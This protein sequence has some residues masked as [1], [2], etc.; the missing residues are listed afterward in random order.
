M[1]HEQSEETRNKLKGLLLRLAARGTRRHFVLLFEKY[2]V[3]DIAEALSD[4]TLEDRSRFFKLHNR[5]SLKDMVEVF[6]QIPLQ[7]QVQLIVEFS[8]AFALRL[9]K[10]MDSDDAASLLSELTSKD[11]DYAQFLIEALPKQDAN[12]LK[13]MMSEVDT[14]TSL[15]ATSVVLF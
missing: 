8:K 12:V 11:Q 2:H 1:S 6:Q 4:L 15:R 13:K 7:D 3:A 14:R 10:Q 5:I 9:L